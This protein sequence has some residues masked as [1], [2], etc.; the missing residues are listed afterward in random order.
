MNAAA[1]GR[2]PARSWLLALVAFAAFTLPPQLLGAWAVQATGDEAGFVERVLLAQLTGCL[3]LLGL[4][5]VAPPGPGFRLPAAALLR[6]LGYYLCFLVLWAVFAFVLYPW[7]LEALDVHL[8]VQP[9]LRYFTRD[10]RPLTGF[11][12][13]VLTVCVFGPCAEEVLFR[14]YLTSA[15]RTRLPP[16]PA[17]VLVAI[18]FGWMHG[19]ELA[20]PIALLGLL[21]AFLRERFASLATCCAA[22]MLH[23]TLTVVLV[24][25]FPKL[26]TWLQSR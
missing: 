8:P 23:N 24:S 4:A 20:L 15:L 18:L 2:S 6:T 10:D 3:A 26:L 5:G 12:P 25:T 9:H 1:S 11:L 22:H 21:F 7:V 14:G 13:A 17:G 16:V 19:K